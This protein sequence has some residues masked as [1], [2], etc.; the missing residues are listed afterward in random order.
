MTGRVD[1]YGR[2]LLPLTFRHPL[3]GATA[4][5]EAWVDTGFGGFLLLPTDQVAALGLPNL[6]PVT[7]GVADGSQVT[8]DTYA[9]LVEWFGVKRSLIALSGR[10]Q[11]ALIGLGLLED[12]TLTIDYPGRIVT[13]VPSATAPPVAGA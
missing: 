10:G 4:D 8:F 2:P 12:C 13:L 11:H 6:G 3:T 5:L 1:D 9:C 7:G